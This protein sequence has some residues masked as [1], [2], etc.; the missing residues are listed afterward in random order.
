MIQKANWRCLQRF[1]NLLLTNAPRFWSKNAGGIRNCG[2]NWKDCFER[3]G[4]PYLFGAFTAADAMYAPVAS[5]FR[6]YISNLGA[7]GD[8]GT[9]AAYVAAIFALPA[10]QDWEAGAKAELAAA[11]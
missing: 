4:G 1:S 9:A 8:D 11:G 2:A 3:Y 5:R 7:Y 10:M 6:T